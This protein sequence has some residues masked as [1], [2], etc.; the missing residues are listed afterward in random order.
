M[1]DRKLANS[2]V[3][4]LS[5]Y[6]LHKRTPQWTYD[7]KWEIL[8]EKLGGKLIEPFQVHTLDSFK[9]NP[10]DPDTT[11]ALQ[12][13]VEQE[14]ANDSEFRQQLA[15]TIGGP[16]AGSRARRTW[17]MVA[18]AALVVVAV[19]I[20]YLIARP[21]GNDP[22]AQPPATVTSTAEV[23]V[24]EST[25]TTT[26]TPESSSA[27]PASSVTGSA[28]PGILGDGG[29]LP[30]GTPVHLTD[31]PRPNDEWN[32]EYGDHDVQFTQYGNSV[33]DVL[34]TCSET[35]RSVE[36]QF[37]L[38]N[39]RSI[40]VEAVGTDS[41]SDSGVAMRFEIFANDNTVEPIKEAVVEPGGSTPME[42]ALPADVFAL[43]LR[44]SLARPPDPDDC[45]E[46]NAVWG[47]PY[48]VAAGS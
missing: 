35:Q 29:S 1:A 28:G 44:A 36:Q 24:T 9:T 17:S 14:I 12:Q 39:F 18:A 2:V 47:S 25:T 46:A 27:A 4:S 11:K 45:L 30:E 19:V 31:L 15:K 20:T 26:S 3:Q 32:F 41:T 22:V 21:S 40:T 37:N 5:H 43:T 23:T 6:L 16:M 38:R 13:Q 10:V 8:L 42:A 48:V 7:A 33:W 34:Y